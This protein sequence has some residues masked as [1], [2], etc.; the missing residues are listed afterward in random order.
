[1]IIDYDLKST[2]GLSVFKKIKN[3]CPGLATIMISLSGSI[4]LAV[5]ATKLG[6]ADF[7]PKPLVAE[8]LKKV[9]ER[10]LEGHREIE[11][12]NLTVLDDPDWLVGQSQKI[13]E[14][15]SISEAAI[16]AKKDILLIG[17]RGIDK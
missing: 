8:T 13:R 9:V 16:N 14:M 17:E 4:P 7:L 6:V 3:I 2:D 10:V 15:L 5:Q 1:M 12:I 11:G